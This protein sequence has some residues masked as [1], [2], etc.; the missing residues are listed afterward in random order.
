MLSSFFRVCLA[1]NCQNQINLVNRSS[2]KECTQCLQRFQNMN[3]K[4]F[5]NYLK[6]KN[7]SS[8]ETL[9]KKK[10]DTYGKKS[11]FTSAR[12]QAIPPVLWL[13]VKPITKLSAVLFGR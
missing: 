2:I 10:L 8:I 1:K 13:I 6:P 12:K 5:S 11:L 4:S 7:N 3:T 9:V